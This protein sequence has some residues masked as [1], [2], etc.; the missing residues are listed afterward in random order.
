MIT[1]FDLWIWGVA[2]IDTPPKGEP[3]SSL[4]ASA[5]ASWRSARLF[6]QEP[7]NT[8]DPDL[9]KNREPSTPEFET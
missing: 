1:E 2:E 6:R 5:N 9:P 7:R 3:P 8:R 4:S